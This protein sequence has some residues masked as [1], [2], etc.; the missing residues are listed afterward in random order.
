M[1]SFKG[2][3]VPLPFDQAMSRSFFLSRTAVRVHEFAKRLL[4]LSCCFAST[5]INQYSGVSWSRV[6]TTVSMLG[7]LFFN[8]CLNSAAY[9]GCPRKRAESRV[10]VPLFFVT[11]RQARQTDDGFE[12]GKQVIEPLNAVTY[13]TTLVDSMSPSVNQSSADK[14]KEWGWTFHADNGKG[15]V[16]DQH[17]A[18]SCDTKIFTDFDALTSQLKNALDKVEDRHF[19]VFVHGCCVDFRCSMRQ[20]S[21]LASSL[22]VPVVAYSWGCSNGYGGSN[23]AYP[24][25]Q[26]RFNEFMVRIL[27]TFPTEKI[28]LVANSLGNSVVVDYCLQRRVEDSGR[29]LDAIFLS[30][31]D[32]DDVAFRSQLPNVARHS[33]KIIVYV[34]RNDFQINLSGTLRWFAYPTMHGERAGHSR[35]MLQAES[36]LTVLDVSPLKLGHVMPYD[37]VA[38]VLLNGGVV[39]H[40]SGQYEYVRQ[41]ENLFRVE[42]LKNDDKK[43]AFKR[44]LSVRLTPGCRCK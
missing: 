18:D 17:D 26:Q 11:D 4:F 32:L 16:L 40:A 35:A 2:S 33:K 29:A 12:F 14:L 21:D 37:S 44:S 10:T 36:T 43:T 22:K 15:S 42:H 25:T 38:D 27:K 13:G 8:G 34:A 28:G 41:T 23:L 30:R 31:A 19:V 20:A 7:L 39:P 1:S 5:N 24:R 3:L 9:A 6:L